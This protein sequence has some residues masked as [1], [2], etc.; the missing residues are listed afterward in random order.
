MPKIKPI[1]LDPITSWEQAEDVLEAIADLNRVDRE[2]RLRADEDRAAIDSHLKF[3]LSETKAE[4]GP[5]LARLE[6][7]VRAHAGDML[8]AKSRRLRFGTVA[9][10]DEPQFSWPK[11]LDTLVQ[12]LREK[13][14]TK[15]L[16]PQEPAVDK[17][18]IM[19]HWEQ[20]PLADLG[21]KR[22]VSSN[23]F[24]VKFPEE[25]VP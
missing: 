14:L 16:V 25:D 9:L 6:A 12:R 13:G 7:F 1:E 5:M 2:N 15:Y 4:L 18:G 8:P 17:R 22:T 11:K 23:V 20:I 10:R 19:A 24:I 3:C 21:V